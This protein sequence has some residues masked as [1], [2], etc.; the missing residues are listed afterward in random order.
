MNVRRL[1]K[2]LALVGAVMAFALAAGEIAVRIAAPASLQPAILQPEAGAAFFGARMMVPV[3]AGGVRYAGRPGARVEIH[4]VEYAHNSLGLRGPEPRDGDASAADTVR[5]LLVGDSNAYGW[6]VAEPDSL[7]ARLE[8]ALGER[9]PGRTFEVQ[10]AAFP[11]YNT[12]DQAALL[13]RLLPALRPQVV[14]AA[15]FVNDLERLGFHVDHAGA[16]FCDPLPAPGAWKPTLWRSHLYRLLSLARLEALRRSG[17][18]E[19]RDDAPR[20]YSLDHLLQM[21]D[22]ARDAGATFAIVDVPLLE[23]SGASQRMRRDGYPAAAASAWLRDVAAAADIPHLELL[24]AVEGEPTALLWASIDRGDHH[25]NARA[26]ER[27]GAALADFLAREA[28]L[29]DG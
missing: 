15:W 18:L 16:L 2:R 10:A 13:R 8:A 4:G 19:A 24:D 3:E 17:T 23:P 22:L 28:L 11:G 6:G 1:L 9:V 7:R 26:H 21:R 27:F 29:P 14:V 20:A 25:P 12:A 5:V